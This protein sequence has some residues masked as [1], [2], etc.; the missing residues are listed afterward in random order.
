MD[1]QLQALMQMMQDMKEKMAAGQELMKTEMK[2]MKTRQDKMKEEM[3]EQIKIG[4]DEMKNEIKDVETGQEEI[5]KEIISAIRK[6][7]K[8]K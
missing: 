4:E 1:A 5:K 8:M 7:L 2:E 6:E 3:S